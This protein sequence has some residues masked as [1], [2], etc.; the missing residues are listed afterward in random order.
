MSI[1]HMRWS[2]L[3]RCTPAELALEDA[4]AALGVPYRVQF[5]GF[6]YGV[7][8]FPDFLLPTLGVVIEVDD[9]SHNTAEKREADAERSQALA[10]AWDVDVVRCTN[11]AAL[12]NP[13]EAVATMLRSVGL[14]PIPEAVKRQR[15]TDSIPRVAKC[16]PK[17]RRASLA[18]ARRKRRTK[19]KGKRSNAR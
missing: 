4:V 11:E 7:R 1:M 9:P 10:A 14:W 8:F 6:L 19:L 16:P 17:A 3:A 15:V 2:R 18:A 12:A 5:P 13:V